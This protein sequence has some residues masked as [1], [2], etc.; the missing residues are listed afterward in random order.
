MKKIDIQTG[1]DNPI[2]REKSGVIKDFGMKTPNGGVVLGAFLQEM[3][4]LMDEEKGLG[5]AAPQG[6]EDLRVCLCR[7]NAGS[8]DEMLFALVNPEVIE[9]SDGRSEEDDAVWDPVWGNAKRG[10]VS[11]DGSVEIDEE[12]CLS[13]PSYY[14]NIARARRIVVKFLD[15]RPLLKKGKSFKGALDEISVELG[16]LNARV[17]QHEIDHLNGKL[18]CDKALS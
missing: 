9:R 11:P 4:K 2:L 15:G 7:L 6:G 8:D 10:A 17:V 12:G 16:G 5:F 3:K 1:K 18:I 14:V 13:L